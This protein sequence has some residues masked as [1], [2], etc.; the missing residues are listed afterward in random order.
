MEQEGQRLMLTSFYEGKNWTSLVEAIEGVTQ[1]HQGLPALVVV[2]G[3][4]GLGKSETVMVYASRFDC[5]YLRA[6]TCWTPRWMLLELAHELGFEG[7]SPVSRLFGDCQRVLRHRLKP[8]FVD[9]ADHLPLRL[10]ETLRDLHDTTGVPVVLV[11]MD[12]VRRKLARYPQFYSRI[13]RVVVFEPLDAS[14][15]QRLALEWCGLE[16]ESNAAESLFKQAEEGDFRL[17][18]KALS[19]LEARV[20]MNMKPGGKLVAG[21]K[22]VEMVGRQMAREHRAA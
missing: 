2:D 3:R 10:L 9:E 6:L 7:I 8:V 13:G 12:Q 19:L 4:A 15:I 21:P 20:K 18:V 1:Q 17:I 22:M 11:G 16:L 14:E 5:V